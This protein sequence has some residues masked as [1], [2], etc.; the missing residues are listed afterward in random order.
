MSIM[1]TYY[2]L[3]A[4]T[5]RIEFDEVQERYAKAMMN[6]ISPSLAMVQ[7]PSEYAK[8]GWEFFEIDLE[9]GAIM[10]DDLEEAKA[11][12]MDVFARTVRE[13]QTERKSQLG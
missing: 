2:N 1:L 5:D 6:T 4:L 3:T 12:F 8:I 7:I 13:W 10:V 9:E 11:R